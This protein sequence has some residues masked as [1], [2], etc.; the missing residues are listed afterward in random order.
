MPLE[1]V[2]SH[3]F[4]ADSDLSAIKPPFFAGFNT[5]I[6]NN[7]KAVSRAGAG[8][9]LMEGIWRF[10]APLP[11][12]HRL[13]KQFVVLGQKKREIKSCSQVFFSGR[14]MGKK[15]NPKLGIIGIKES[16]V[17]KRGDSKIIISTQ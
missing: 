14:G 1:A 11:L 16:F 7:A 6:I 17:F 4:P 15:A 10:A 5:F 3:L 2:K 12:T 13:Y 9:E 8:Q